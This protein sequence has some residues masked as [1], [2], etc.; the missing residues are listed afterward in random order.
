MDWQST[1]KG[2]GNF[3]MLERSLS[4]N[5]REAYVRDVSKL[6]AFLNMR[7][8]EIGPEGLELQ[9]LSEFLQWLNELGLTFGVA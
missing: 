3:L 8:L 7:E 1:I 9:H 5:T 6:A 4:T 2:F